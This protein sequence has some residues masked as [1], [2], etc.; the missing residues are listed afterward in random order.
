[1]SIV[2]NCREDIR[3]PGAEQQHNMSICMSTGVH[4]IDVFV[5][6]SAVIVCE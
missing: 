2:T 5:E 1:M 4:P 3:M 6:Q